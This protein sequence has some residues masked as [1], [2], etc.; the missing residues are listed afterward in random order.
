M[1]L[2]T[3]VVTGVAAG[4]VGTLAM[5]SLWFRRARRS[6]SDASFREWE[7]GG[8]TESFDDA[9]APAQVGRKFAAKVGNRA[10]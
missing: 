10:P 3:T 7:F 4:S 5:D 1:E 2:T 6:G 9:G 8:D